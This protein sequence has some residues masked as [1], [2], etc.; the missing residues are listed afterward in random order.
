MGATAAG[1][2]FAIL[3]MLPWGEA[4]SLE[5]DRSESSA[6]ETGIE[7]IVVIDS[8]SISALLLAEK[9]RVIDSIQSIHDLESVLKSNSESILRK[10]PINIREADPKKY[11]TMRLIPRPRRFDS[12]MR[13]RQALPNHS[14]RSRKIRV[15]PPQK[16]HPRS[17]RKR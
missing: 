13:F 8:A 10:Y 7:T 12:T 16:S 17:P 3:W 9:Q 11:N 4:K 1:L 6:F 15:L 14:D 2:L 5:Q